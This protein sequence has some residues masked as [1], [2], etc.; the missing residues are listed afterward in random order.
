LNPRDAR[1]SVRVST[2]CGNQRLAADA[3]W[4]YDSEHP[5]Q[6]NYNVTETNHRAYMLD[7]PQEANQKLQSR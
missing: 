4:N 1:Y 5:G 2:G 6:I 7:A 3:H